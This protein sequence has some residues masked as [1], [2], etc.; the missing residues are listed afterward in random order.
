MIVAI[1]LK[2]TQ[3]QDISFHLSEDE[4]LDGKMQISFDVGY[5]ETEERNFLVTFQGVS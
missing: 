5:D 2:K 1:S 3:A 4:M